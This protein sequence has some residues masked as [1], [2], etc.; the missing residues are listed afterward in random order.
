MDYLLKRKTLAQALKKAGY[1]VISPFK[2]QL[3]WV[4]VAILGRRSI[5]I[6]F[7]AGSYESSVERLTSH[8]FREIYIVGDCD[9]CTSEAELIED[10]NIELEDVEEN[11][12]V[13]RIEMEESK[14]KA[15]GIED[16]TAFIYIVGEVYEEEADKYSYKSLK[17]V[18]PELKRWGF[19]SSSTREKIKPKFFASLSYEGYRLAEEVI[20]KR[21]KIFEKKLRKMAKDPMM[22]LIALGLSR[23]LKL[24]ELDN[25]LKELDIKSLLEFMKK[26]PLNLKAIFSTQLN[27][28]LQFSEFLVNTALNTKAVEVAE[29]LLR[30]GL[31]AKVN[32]YSPF[33]YEMGEEYMFA[34]EAIEALLKFSY[35]EIDRDIIAEFLSLVYPL[36]SSDVF[37]ILNMSREYLMKAKDMGV[38]EFDG[39]HFSIKENFENYARVRLAMLIEKAIQS[40][41]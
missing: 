1:R 24:K 19:V 39:T 41:S 15:K 26:T 28:K 25:E 38:C 5:G 37:P 33:G 14:L 12:I 3:G 29:K 13:G 17:L 6:D 21:L 34:R 4:D 7:C 16:A 8:P 32:L 20:G 27:P 18:L 10:L 2:V 11:S 35:A 9:G 31:A 22:Y 30:M 23:S 36:Y 40:L